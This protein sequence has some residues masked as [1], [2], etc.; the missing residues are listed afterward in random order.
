MIFGSYGQ[1]I[2]CPVSGH[3]TVFRVVVVASG[4]KSAALLGSFT[5]EKPEGG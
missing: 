2:F 3:F 4:S 1:F 5:A